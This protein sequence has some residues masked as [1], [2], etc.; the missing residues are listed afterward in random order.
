MEVE[1]GGNGV[2][3]AK[4]RLPAK[5]REMTEWQG[6]PALGQGWLLRRSQFGGEGMAKAR[7]GD[8]EG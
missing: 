4:R 6:A 5:G 8:S 2:W 7:G 3:E 1:G